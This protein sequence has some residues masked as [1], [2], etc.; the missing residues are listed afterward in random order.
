MALRILSVF[1]SLSNLAVWIP[2]TTNSLGYFFSSRARSGSVWMQLMQH[3]VQKSRRTIL[4]RRSFMR[5]GPAVFSQA[6]PPFNSGASGRPS[7]LLS[8]GRWFLGR[9]RPRGPTNAV[10]EQIPAHQ[11][12]ER[13]THG[14]NP[15]TGVRNR[16][17]GGERFRRQG[18]L[19]LTSGARQTLLTIL[20]QA[21]Q[22]GTEQSCFRGPASGLS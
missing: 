17:R 18:S 4:P 3:S 20:G 16:A 7:S 13:Q 10:L 22:G 2:T 8:F 19:A 9:D 5:T 14:E 12:D 21:P 6:T 15:P 11:S 1:F